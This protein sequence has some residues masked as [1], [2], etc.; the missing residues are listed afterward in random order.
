[1]SENRQT[2]PDD[3]YFVTLTIMGWINLFDREE[4][5]SIIIQNLRY[6]QEKENLDIFS[7]V[8]MSNHLHM[9]CRRKGFDLKELLGRFKS[10]TSKQFIKEIHENIKE[11][12]KEWLLQLFGDYAKENKQYKGFHI[13]QYTNFPTLLYSNEVIDQKVNYIHENPV[14]AGLVTEAAFYRYS[15]A[16]QDG[17]IKVME[18]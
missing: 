18:L 7:Y 8:I 4:Y 9:V 17:P 13:W 16:C 14:R 12:R 2:S 3:L 15:S 10:V 5:K 11:S 6:C 1:M